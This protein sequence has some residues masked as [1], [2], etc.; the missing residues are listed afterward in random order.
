MRQSCKKLL[1]ERNH[2]TCGG[3][4]CRTAACTIRGG[5]QCEIHNSIES[6]IGGQ[7]RRRRENKR[8]RTCNDAIGK[9][10]HQLI[11]TRHRSRVVSIQCITRS[12]EA[13]RKCNFRARV[14]CS[15]NVLVGNQSYAV[16]GYELTTA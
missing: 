6:R 13:T 15:K 4:A 5:R 11:V 12:S 8:L 14:I 16:P 9:S 2:Y 1:W 10:D 7:V 3:V